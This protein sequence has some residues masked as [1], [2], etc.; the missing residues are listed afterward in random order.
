MERNFHLQL[1]LA[2]ST[3]THVSK[4]ISQGTVTSFQVHMLL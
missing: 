3:V 4:N 2:L 1:S